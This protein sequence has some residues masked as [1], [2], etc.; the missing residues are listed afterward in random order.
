MVNWAQDSD[1]AVCISLCVA[2]ELYERGSQTGGG[3]EEKSAGISVKWL[4]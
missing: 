4:V 1:K 2:F 3:N